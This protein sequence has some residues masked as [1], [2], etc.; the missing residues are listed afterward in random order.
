MRPFVTFG[1]VTILGI[2]V[3]TATSNA[4]AGQL[5]AVVRLPDDVLMQ[6]LLDQGPMVQIEF[7]E[8]DRYQKGLAIV[9]IQA[10]PETVWQALTDFRGYPGFMPRVEETEV[11][12]KGDATFVDFELDTPLVS[13]AYTNRYLMDPA[14]RW[15]KVETVKGDA[16]GSQFT[17]HLRP[18]G[19][20]TRVY[21]G[22]VVRNF[23]SIAQRLD[24]DQQT[25]TIGINVVTLLSAAKAVK[26]RAEALHQGTA[27]KGTR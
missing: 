6:K 15:L 5:S 13:T 4:N 27:H 17:W 7:N 1:L 20:G 22:G 14:H 24:D 23:S 3:W 16:K 10:P 21:N 2:S 25:I 19:N 26:K 18:Q 12:K 8:R 9:D 11:R